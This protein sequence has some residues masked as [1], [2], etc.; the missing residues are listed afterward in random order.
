MTAITPETGGSIA[1]FDAN[2]IERFRAGDPDV[3]DDF[4]AT[5]RAPDDTEIINGVSNVFKII[6][7]GTLSKTVGAGAIGSTTVNLP[8]LGTFAA[9][10]V[11]IGIVSSG[12]AGTGD[13][14]IGHEFVVEA[15]VYTAL[16]SGGAV[17]HPVTAIE[18]MTT[19]SAKLEG[20]GTVTVTLAIFNV[21]GP[22]SITRYG[23]Y[24]VM[25]EA[26]L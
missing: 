17:T 9:V 23:R 7:S 11:M 6:A 13:K 4:A 25:Q 15:N 3:G 14:F 12:T 19:I 26:A 16:T 5:V 22:G 1:V 18:T 10:P 24:Y 8:A 2:D 20:D 21:T